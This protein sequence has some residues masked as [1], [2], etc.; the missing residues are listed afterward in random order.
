MLATG[1]QREVVVGLDLMLD[2][3][4]PLRNYGPA[5]GTVI[6]SNPSRPPG[7][8]IQISRMSD[9]S[10]RELGERQHVEAPLTITDKVRRYQNEQENEKEIVYR[11]QDAIRDN[12]RVNSTNA[13]DRGDAMGREASEANE[14]ATE[15]AR[16]KGLSRMDAAIEG[17][18]AAAAARAKSVDQA[19]LDHMV[20][21]DIVDAT[22]MSGLK[23]KDAIELW[24]NLS[25]IRI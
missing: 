4:A 5:L 14:V 22:T 21:N 17:A 10:P 23:A 6:A 24:V 8:N 25:L 18:K 3:V 2:R 16:Q 19:L 20:A 1:V 12:Q 7:S 13:L 9:P 15:L 11:D